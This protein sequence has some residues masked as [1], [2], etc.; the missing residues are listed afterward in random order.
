MAT[1]KGIWNLQ[2]VRDKQLQDLWSYAGSADEAGTLWGWGDG[3]TGRLGTNNNINYSSPI[4]IGS[5]ENWNTLGADGRVLTMNAAIKDDGTLYTWGENSEGR[6]GQNQAGTGWPSYTN[7]KSSPVQVPGTTWSTFSR[8]S[9]TVA[10]IK[11]D[12]TMWVWGDN[13]AGQLGLNQGDVSYSSPTQLPGTTWKAVSCAA[14]Y[15]AATKTDGTLWVWGQN[16]NS[17]QLGQNNIT[18]YSSPVQVPGTNW[19]FTYVAEREMWATK[20]NGELWAWGYNNDGQLAQNTNGDNT[21][22]YSSPVQIPG[23]WAVGQNK[24]AGGYYNFFA[25]KG[26]GT[27]WFMGEGGYNSNGQNNQTEYSSPVQIPGTTWDELAAGTT[28]AGAIK[29]DGTLWTWGANSAGQLGQNGTSTTNSPVQIPGSW[30]TG[31]GAIISGW[32]NFMAIKQP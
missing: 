32:N 16:N 26:N 21:A 11:T 29:T 3:S 31:D 13:G 20:T 18:Q 27:L 28:Q 17:G 22:N 6:L 30:K 24:M 25:I 4:Q 7:I 10:A 1:K 9:N 8:S 14:A 23:T 2:Q 5:A 19:A 12:G 15:T